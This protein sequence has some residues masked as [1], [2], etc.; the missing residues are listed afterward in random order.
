MTMCLKTLIDLW[1]ETDFFEILAD[2][3]ATWFSEFP[4]PWDFSPET[5]DLE[6]FLNHS[7]QKPVCPIVRN[8]VKVSETDSLTD[9][10]RERL[11]K[12]CYDLY[13][14]KWSKL[15]ETMVAE[16]NP[17]ENY[18]MVEEMDKDTSGTDD[19]TH[20][21]VITG[22]A[23]RQDNV[24]GFNDTST[25]GVPQSA[26]TAGNTDTH[27]GKDERSMSGTEDYTLTRHGNIGVTTSQ[28]M[29]ESERQLFLWDYFKQV[30]A[31]ID[32]VLCLQIY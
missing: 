10:D 23:N 6:Y 22:T 9:A 25:T 21:H 26:S 29:L 12:M 7:G 14:L 1:P 3:A 15:W 24:F 4:I 5:L 27:S 20:G 18:D 32:T 30:F 8:F 28:Q 13:K 31:D 17:L 11:V 16:Y 19:L 2:N